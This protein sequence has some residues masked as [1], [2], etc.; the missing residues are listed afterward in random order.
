MS[1]HWSYSHRCSLRVALILTTTP[2]PPSPQHSLAVIVS[3]RYPR[4][5]KYRY[6]SVE[7]TRKLDIGKQGK[8]SGRWTNELSGGQT[9]RQADRQTFGEFQWT[10]RMPQSSMRTHT[11]WT[12]GGPRAPCSRQPGCWHP[13]HPSHRHCTQR[14]PGGGLLWCCCRSS[15]S[16]HRS[17]SL[18]AAARLFGAHSPVPVSKQRVRCSHPGLNLQS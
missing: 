2:S 18:Q 14:L 10:G 7:K 12:A 16:T 6:M 13:V 9:D 8:Q 3:L 1:C 5:G 11:G 15:G 17:R 4:L